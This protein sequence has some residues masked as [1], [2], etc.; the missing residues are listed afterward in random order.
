MSG[1]SAAMTIV[2]VAS[3]VLRLNPRRDRHAPY[4]RCASGVKSEFSHARLP[5]GGHEQRNFFLRHRDA[6]RQSAQEFS[7]RLRVDFLAAALAL[8]QWRA[9]NF[10]TMDELHIGDV[11]AHI[12]RRAQAVLEVARTL[13]GLKKYGLQVVAFE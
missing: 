12:E 9:Q 1:I 6:H 5:F 11:A 2:A 7:I 8:Y 13:A 3:A 10:T 4:R